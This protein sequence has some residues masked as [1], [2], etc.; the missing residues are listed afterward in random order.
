V[1]YLV[2]SLDFRLMTLGLWAWCEEEYIHSLNERVVIFG[3][4]Q[5]DPLD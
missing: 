2:K 1:E 5:I 3:Q 4:Q